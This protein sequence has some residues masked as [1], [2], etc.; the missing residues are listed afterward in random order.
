MSIKKDLDVFVSHSWI[1]EQREKNCSFWQPFFKAIETFSSC[2]DPELRYGKVCAFFSFPVDF[3]CLLSSVPIH[4]SRSSGPCLP[5]PVSLPLFPCLTCSVSCLPSS[6]SCHH[7][8]FSC[9]PFSVPCLM[10]YVPHLTCSAPCLPSSVPC[11]P[12]SMSPVLCAPSPHSQPLGNG[13]HYSGVG[14]QNWPARSEI[15]PEK[16]AMTVRVNSCLY[17]RNVYSTGAKV[18]WVLCMSDPHSQTIREW[19]RD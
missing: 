6:V 2:F 18:G 15:L 11:L 19:K 4:I 12:S 7:V 14:G 8:P 17:K 16:T 3:A 13:L 9:L 1:L 10:F 5:F